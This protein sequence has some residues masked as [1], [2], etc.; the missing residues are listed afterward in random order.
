MAEKKAP[1]S[2]S[3]TVSEPT[4]MPLPESLVQRAK[5][6]PLPPSGGS[7]QQDPLTGALVKVV[8]RQDKQ[9]VVPEKE[10]E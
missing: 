8:E 6:T 5:E 10:K 7:W 4:A 1:G 9:A 2:P 3:A